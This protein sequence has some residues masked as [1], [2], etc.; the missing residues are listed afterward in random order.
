M[1]G[2]CNMFLV[3]SS[4]TLIGRVLHNNSAWAVVMYH[5]GQIRE[6]EI[7]GSRDDALTACD[8]KKQLLVSN[9]SL[10]SRLALHRCPPPEDYRIP[11]SSQM[12]ACSAKVK[13]PPL[14]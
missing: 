14:Q 10:I 6:Q 4:D 5:R 12:F 8:E 1:P 3:Y 9:F 11:N 13:H 2:T 7:Y